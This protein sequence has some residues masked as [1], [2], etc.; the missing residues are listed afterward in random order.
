MGI[1]SRTVATLSVHR[2]RQLEERMAAK[3][4]ADPGLVLPSTRGTIRRRA[5]IVASLRRLLARADLPLDVRFHDLRHTAATLA[6]RQGYRSRSSP[7]CSD[8]PTR[9]D[10]EALCS[11]PRRQAR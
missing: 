8:T 3:S 2:S 4:W 11:R 7:R 6:I 5:S 9:H 1:G 10:P